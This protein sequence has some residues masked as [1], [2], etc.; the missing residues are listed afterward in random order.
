MQSILVVEKNES[1]SE[2]NAE[3][4]S[5]KEL[6]E[7]AGFLATLV[8][9][10]TAAIETLQKNSFD[11]IISDLPFSDRS[12]FYFLQFLRKK[13]RNKK[14]PF[15]FVSKYN[16][17]KNVIKGLNLGANDFISRPF[18]NEEF[19]ARVNAHLRVSQLLNST[20]EDSAKKLDPILELKEPY[21]FG[22]FTINFQ[23]VTLS[24]N[25]EIIPLT[26]QE[27]K[28]LAYLIEH[29][30]LAVKKE[31]ILDKLWKYDLSVG[32]R[33]IYTHISWLRDKLRTEEHPQG[34]IQTV[35]QVGY[36]FVEEG[37]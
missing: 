3:S 7:G 36:M 33:T 21:S 24:K 34:Y 35:R 8:H 37:L 28:L 5:V 32:L 10:T 26:F 9:T 13:L 25:D 29:K 18:V 22:P 14:T 11:L 6:L 15:V 31:D 16:A 20:D 27:F 30:G 1:S 17:S 4:S 2:S 19:L 23:K 12:G